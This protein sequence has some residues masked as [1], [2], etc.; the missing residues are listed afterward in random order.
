MLQR[1][2]CRSLGTQDERAELAQHCCTW[3]TLYSPLS[4]VHWLNPSWCLKVMDVWATRPFA[5]WVKSMILLKEKASVLLHSVMRG[6]FIWK[7]EHLWVH[8]PRQ[9]PRGRKGL[10]NLTSCW[11]LRVRKKSTWA[12][13]QAY[14]KP[15]GVGS[16]ERA[17]EQLVW[18]SSAFLLGIQECLSL[19]PGC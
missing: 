11:Q 10:A 13:P 4:M 5:K 1:G 6:I 15:C 8:Q 19:L 16:P 9:S 12:E 2:R 14:D 17:G 18:I 7:T 3:D